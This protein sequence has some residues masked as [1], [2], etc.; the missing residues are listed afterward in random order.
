MLC[1]DGWC[2]SVSPDT[3]VAE[4]LSRQLRLRD[5]LALVVGA[6]IGSAIF[7]IP[8][9]V[10]AAQPSAAAALLAF[11]AGGLLSFLG[12]LAYAELG[13]MFPRTGG[14]YVY[15]REA[16]GP[17]PSFLCGWSHFLVIQTGGIAALAV[18]FS[19]LLAAIVPLSPLAVRLSAPCLIVAL[20]I[21]NYRGVRAGAWTGNF[22][23]ILKVG[24]LLL[25][26]AAITTQTR[27]VGID[28]SWPEDWHLSQMAVAIV[29]ILWAF[30]GWNLVTFVSGE[31]RDARRNIPLA[32]GLGLLIVLAVYVASLWSYL[33]VLTVPEIISST[34]VAPQAAIR[35][36]GSAGGTLVTLTM[37]VAVI[38]STNASVLA[39]PRLYYAQ[40]RD[41]MFFRPFARVHPL[42]HTPSTGLVLQCIWASV[43]SLTGSYEMLLTSCVFVA[44]L[45]YGSCAAGVI[46]LRWRAPELPRTYRMWG[47]PWTTAVFSLTAAAVVTGSFLTRPLPSGA[48]LALMLAGIPLYVRWRRRTM[49][50]CNM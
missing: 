17:F 36:M 11:L 16:W 35:V 50:P 39:A 19:T 47:A 43:L 6:V 32:L 44:W 8:S 13:S 12:A 15:L 30:E 1:A 34:A 31:V 14:E 10:L 9:T 2:C 7:L 20:T 27:P 26:L 33:R 40:A 42:F 49:D 29:P 5:A 21:V 18:G 3:T 45:I 4:G 25:M 46:V 37:I 23:T 28:W 38:G 41:G 22:F 24:G 48:G